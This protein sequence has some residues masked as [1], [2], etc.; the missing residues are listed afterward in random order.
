[1]VLPVIEA[2]SPVYGPVDGGTPVLIRGSGLAGATKVRF[3][4]DQSELVTAHSETEIATLSPKARVGG[5]AL[6]T[7]YVG[8]TPSNSLTFNYIARIWGGDRKTVFWIEVG[9]LLLLLSLGAA[10]ASWPPFKSFF[11]HDLGAVPI[12]IPWFA[13]LGGVTASLT[14]V[15]G[16]TDDWDPRYFFWHIARPFMA[17]VLGS[18]AYLIFLGGVLAS[19]SAA[20]SAT[21]STAGI[22]GISYDVIA[23]VGGYREDVLR[24]LIK[25]V[26]DLILNP[27]AAAAEPP[28][29]PLIAPLYLPAGAGPGNAPPE[30]TT[31]AAAPPN[32]N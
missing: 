28:R 19:G 4:F 32:S 30:T 11:S 16:H 20:V 26:V 2:I 9:Y 23:F 27:P 15:F 18:I 22:Q 31:V 25:R 8:D 17:I 7:V 14:A 29:K 12:I 21:P 13:A 3:G 6:V 10:Y 24:T 1:M 5:N